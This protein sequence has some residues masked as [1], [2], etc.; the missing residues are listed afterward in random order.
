MTVIGITNQRWRRR[1]VAVAIAALVSSF[2]AAQPAAAATVRC[3]PQQKSFSVYEAQIPA[4]IGTLTLNTN[5]CMSGSTQT[6]SSASMKW[7][8][9][10]LGAGMGYRFDNNTTQRLTSGSWVSSGTLKLCVPTQISPLCAYGE[11]FKITH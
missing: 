2:V 6:S 5:I 4:P 10:P 11:A 3:N 7:S 1:L 9:S 8:A